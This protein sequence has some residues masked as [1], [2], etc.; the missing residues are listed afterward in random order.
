M[1]TKGRQGQYKRKMARIRID[2]KISR[3]EDDTT[4]LNIDRANS[5]DETGPSLEHKNRG[6]T[7]ASH[8]IRQA[9][10]TIIDTTRA[11]STMVVILQGR[12]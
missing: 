4:P 2:S 6:D 3:A 5:Q 12:L 10:N 1:T 9:H 8:Q 11:S 7:H